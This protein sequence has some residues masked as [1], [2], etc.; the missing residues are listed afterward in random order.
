M[1]AASLLLVIF[2]SA[3]T[4]FVLGRF[5]LNWQYHETHAGYRQA[6]IIAATREL[7]HSLLNDG[8]AAPA[9][10]IRHRNSLGLVIERFIQ[11]FGTPQM[12]KQP[13]NYPVLYDPEQAG[14]WHFY[15][16]HIKPVM[17]D[18]NNNGFIGWMP[19]I[20][21][22]KRMRTLWHLSRRLEEVIMAQETLRMYE[23]TYQVR[24][25]HQVNAATVKVRNTGNT[26]VDAQTQK[27]ESKM[28][29]LEGYWQHWLT[30]V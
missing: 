27:Y 13:G 24:V 19:W 9:L 2:T 3:L 21:N 15:D 26:A 29:E 17:A 25:F 1:T 18:L 4:S 22:M 20:L 16:E 28:R 12:K 10:R 6:R 11:A 30:L 8:E 23:S 14:S 7:H 5:Y